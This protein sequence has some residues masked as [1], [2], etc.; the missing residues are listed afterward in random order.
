[1]VKP[2]S[3]TPH[4]LRHYNLSFIDQI[5]AQ[6]NGSLVYF[7]DADDVAN[8]LNINEASNL[9]KKS[10]SQVL[11]LFCPLAGRL[12]ND[13]LTVDCNDEGVPFIE[14]RINFS[15]SHVTDSS[16]TDDVC[17]LLPY[18][19]D[20][21]VDTVLGVQ[22]NVFDCGGIAIGVCISH[23]VADAMSDL[24]F[25]KNWAAVTRGE[26][27]EQIRIHFQSSSLF[28]PKDMLGFD[29]NLYIGK[30]KIVGKRFVFEASVIESLRTKYSKNVLEGQKPP[31]RVV[32]LST[33]L[34]TRFVAATKKEG[35][36]Q[37]H[38]V[39]WTANLRPRMEPP[40][41]EYA[42]G[43]YYWYLQTFPMLDEQG[44]CNDL[45][46]LLGRELSKIDKDFVVKIRESEEWN[47]ISE[48]MVR[49][50]EKGEMV[51][52]SVTS[53]CRFPMYEVDFGWGNP[54]MALLPTWKFKNMVCLKDTKSGG[55]IE[56]YVNLT[57]DDMA[58]FERDEELF[59]YVSTTGLQ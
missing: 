24:Q 14:T 42:F 7:F 11:S 23:K 52:F 34:W 15:V 51:L 33:F 35:S 38:L 22:F 50:I 18:D 31:T 40:L 36:K 53:L 19:M 28:P 25:M 48:E 44:E 5:T 13:N 46:R 37:I 39:G 8:K 6:I 2:S 43:N 27:A 57:G 59:A 41:P 30:Q 12:L 49:E 9:L 55:G 26:P 4:H 16:S 45:G 17:K 32:A 47:P 10:L 58:K 3:P 54:T 1:M 21:V 56:A 20:E 29:P